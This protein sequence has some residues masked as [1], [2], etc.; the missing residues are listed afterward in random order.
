[1]PSTGSTP[2]NIQSR[3]F[4]EQIALIYRLTPHTLAMS[5]IGSTL[6][7]VVLWPSAPRA[8]LVAW[9][10][11]HHLITGARYLLIR[12]YRRAAP[13]ADAITPW[14][15]RFVVGTIAAGT[16]WGVCGTALFP[17]AGNATQFFIGLYLVGVAATGMFTLS[18]YFLSFVPL[19]GGTLVP[20]AVSLLASGI[21]GLQ[22]TGAATFLF[23]YIVLA[24]ARRFEQM[25]IDSIRLRLQLSEAKEAAE[26]ANR[27]KSRFL[28]NMSHEIRTP[29]NGVLGIAELLLATPLSE[30]QHKRLETLYRSGRELLDVINDILDFSKIEAGKLEL[31]ETVFDLQAMLGEL[32]EAF[33]T[34][35]AAKGLA[36]STQISA[37]VP[38]AVEGDLTRLRQVLINL[39]GNAIRFTDAGGVSL[40]VARGDDGR[41][42][43]AVADTGVGLTADDCGRIFDAFAQAD[44]SDSRRHGG[45]GL[46]LA[47]SRQIVTLMGGE[48][49]V[50]SKPGQGSTFWFVLPLR[51]GHLPA[52]Q[53]APAVSAP[54]LQTLRGHVLLVEDNSVN[55]M[56]AE[57]FLRRFG[58]QVS[59]AVDG[60]QAVDKTAEQ[61]FDLVL[62]D[63]QMPNVD[64][65]EATH[66]IR[67]R[68]SA[69]QDGDSTPPL[70]IIA[71]TANAFEADRERCL[72]AGMNDFVA[73]PFKQTELYA[74][75]ARW[76]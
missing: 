27:A 48:I 40:S 43:F 73:K 58:L 70:P 71:L 54:T 35:A 21:T 2:D 34:S 72:E 11:L 63:C 51:P 61:R 67:A 20:M 50:D 60:Q 76:L 12:A 57:A 74:T 6:I 39:L 5:M 41:I 18:A 32:V 30:I 16:V 24:N 10:L 14:V 44:D 38:L 9:Y 29:M 28:A 75:L 7:L 49:G 26:A 64:G 59:V 66:L 22:L 42:R 1:M 62:M 52:P 8:L 55:R 68:E 13:T 33:A 23:L 15:R 25:T 45:T 65:F 36:L 53:P 47:I 69:R 56:V 31:R 19:A 3:V 17:A 4:A 46:G 37:D